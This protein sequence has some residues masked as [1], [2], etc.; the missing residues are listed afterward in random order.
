MKP[1]VGTQKVFESL[2]PKEIEE[3]ISLVTRYKNALAQKNSRIMMGP[4]DNVI[5]TGLAEE[6][7]ADILQGIR[8]SIPSLDSDYSSDNSRGLIHLNGRQVF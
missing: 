7:F 2:T 8:S 6:D 5:W 3:E 1:K 4:P